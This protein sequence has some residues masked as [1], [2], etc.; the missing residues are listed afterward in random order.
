M[1]LRLNHRLPG[2]KRHFS[3]AVDAAG[4]VM[5]RRMRLLS[6]ARLTFSRLHSDSLGIRGL[7]DDLM[8]L[9]RLVRASARGQYREAPWKSILYATAALLYFLNPVDLI[10]DTLL[11]IGFVDDAAVVAAVVR[12]LHRDLRRFERWEAEQSIMPG[13]EELFENGQ[14][15]ALDA[16][17]DPLQERPRAEVYV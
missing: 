16:A 10:P 12:A 5:R 6:V 3:R 2:L 8:L 1:E 7:R 4:V 14:T 9:S 11:V 13:R 17:I 15:G